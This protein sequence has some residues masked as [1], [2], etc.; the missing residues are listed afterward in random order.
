MFSFSGQGIR[1]QFQLH[2]MLGVAGSQLCCISDSGLTL[3][4]L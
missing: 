2:A 3:F 4:I 1:F